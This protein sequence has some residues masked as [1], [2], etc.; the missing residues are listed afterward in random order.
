M[1]ATIKVCRKEIE[2]RLIKQSISVMRK[3]ISAISKCLELSSKTLEKSIEPYQLFASTLY[4]NINKNAHLEMIN[5]VPVVQTFLT[6]LRN[7]GM[8]IETLTSGPG[9]VFTFKDLNDCVQ[10]LCY[11]MITQSEKESKNRSQSLHILI[12]NLMNLV[13]IKDCKLEGLQSKLEMMQENITKIVNSRIY[14]RGNAMIFELD[15]V[16]RELR[17]YQDHIMLFEDE[18]REYIKQEFRE[19]LTSKELQLDLKT[20]QMDDI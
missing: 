16:S 8:D 9:I 11:E 6:R 19:K 7:R 13:Y 14:E 2:V 5:R 20:K 3:H 1:K 18:L 10:T 4:D 15:R 17:F 12:K